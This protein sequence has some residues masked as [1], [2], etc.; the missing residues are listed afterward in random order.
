MRC[1]PAR[2]ADEGVDGGGG[3]G[4][5]ALVERGDRRGRGWLL[6]SD[7]GVRVGAGE[8]EEEGV[9]NNEEEREDGRK[10]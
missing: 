10:K 7:S 9:K 3:G 8:E 2:G 4:G 1:P 5:F 6:M